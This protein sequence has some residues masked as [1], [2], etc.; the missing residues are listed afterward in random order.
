VVGEPKA[1]GRG[2]ASAAICAAC[3]FIFDELGFRK[4]TAGYHAINI[5]MR[6]AFETNGFHVEGVLREQLYFRGEVVDHILVCKFGK[7]KA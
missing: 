2:I 7:G 1:W 6:R 4:V 3:R 5:G